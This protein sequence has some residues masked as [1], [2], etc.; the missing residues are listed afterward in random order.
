VDIKVYRY[1]YRFTR[2]IESGTCGDE[3]EHKDKD[4]S[5]H[6]ARQRHPLD[7]KLNHACPLAWLSLRSNEGGGQ[8]PRDGM[9]GN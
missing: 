2:G 6:A 9:D 7:P 1:R 4:G 3:E 8:E 5:G